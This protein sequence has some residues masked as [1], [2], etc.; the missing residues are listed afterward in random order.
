MVLAPAAHNNV[1]LAFCRD[2]FPE[3]GLGGHRT[4]KLSR[5]FYR[6]GS[7]AESIKVRLHASKS[8]AVTVNLAVIRQRFGGDG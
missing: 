5:W 4:P 8:A 1:V 6:L 7:C 3:V 2:G